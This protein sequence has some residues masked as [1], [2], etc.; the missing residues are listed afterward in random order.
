MGSADTE[1]VLALEIADPEVDAGAPLPA[2]GGA[3][4]AAMLARVGTFGRDGVLFAGEPEL[5]SA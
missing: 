5:D 4:P 1:R 2:G 3:A